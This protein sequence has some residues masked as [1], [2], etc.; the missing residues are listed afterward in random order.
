MKDKLDV[1]MEIAV[2]EHCL[3]HAISLAH[4]VNTGDSPTKGIIEMAQ[5]FYDWVT[6]E[7][8]K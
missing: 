3:D 4:R 8:T 5:K 2:R 6:S 7:N 1:G